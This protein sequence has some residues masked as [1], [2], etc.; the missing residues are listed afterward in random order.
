[1]CDNFGKRQTDDVPATP[2]KRIKVLEDSH[3]LATS[4]SSSNS[5][6]T[7]VEASAQGNY[8]QQPVADFEDGF[9]KTVPTPIRYCSEL[10]LQ[11]EEL[12][13]YCLVK[14]SS[15]P[16]NIGFAKGLTAD[17]CLSTINLIQYSLSCIWNLP[18]V[19]WAKN[20]MSEQFF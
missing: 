4:A 8:R 16:G 1:M 10:P 14:V 2:C 17:I 12:L 5:S 11:P 13:L 15:P 18:Y 6:T 9:A 20:I 7:V 19:I 3:R